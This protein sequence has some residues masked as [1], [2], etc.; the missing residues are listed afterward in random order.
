MG[1]LCQLKSS[2]TNAKGELM[3]H[4]HVRLS[5]VG[6]DHVVVVTVEDEFVGAA[7]VPDA[8]PTF[9]ALSPVDVPLP[10][11]DYVFWV[12]KDGDTTPISGRTLASV[13]QQQDSKPQ[14]LEILVKP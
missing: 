10:E 6:R 5:F 4:A 8:G 1:M 3:G 11:A 13:R 12:T 2:S 14:I 9:S 7:I